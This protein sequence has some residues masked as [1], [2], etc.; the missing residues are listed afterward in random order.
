MAKNA[1]IVSAEE[2]DALIKGW[3]ET[4]GADVD[5]YFPMRFWAIAMIAAFY[6]YLTLFA[7]E[8]TALK[9]ASDPMEIARVS[10]YLYFR[11]WFLLGA[12]TFATYAY[13]KNRYVG[14]VFMVSLILGISNLISDIFNIY[15]EQLANPPTTLTLTL[16]IRVLA[17]WLCFLCVRNASR[18]PEPND[19]F[20]P[21]L[22]FRTR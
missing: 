21:L 3:G 2:L 13:A 16:L 14:L 17:L 15:W 18:M 12:F 9:L 1:P 8:K 22:P 5:R 7:A 6:L 10:S 11:G 20:N 4:T 19:R